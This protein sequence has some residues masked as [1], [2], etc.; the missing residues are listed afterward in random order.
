MRRCIVL[1][2]LIILAAAIAVRPAR[3]TEQLALVPPVT[4]DAAS[5]AAPPP[6]PVAAPSAAAAYAVAIPLV[7]APER[8]ASID[9][10]YELEVMRL[11]NVA[12]V[13]AGLVPLMEDAAITQAA[14]MFAA[15]VVDRD[16]TWHISPV[17]GAPWD[18]MRAMGFDKTAG[19]EI[20]VIGGGE[21]TP[22]ELVQLWMESSAHH[23]IMF[24][25]NACYV[26]AG[27]AHDTTDIAPVLWLSRTLILVANHPW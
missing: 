16:L 9:R 25:P 23:A 1:T 8:Y 5:A 2:S 14:R 13:N 19:G 26:G 20:M 17:S 15:E 6:P 7:Q 27:L 24:D 12:R 18:R 22:A 21:A 10:V 11:I 4:P 3:A